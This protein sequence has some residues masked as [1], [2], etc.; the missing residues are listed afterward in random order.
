MSVMLSCSCGTEIAVASREAARGLKCP[1]CGK[2]AGDALPEAEIKPAPPADNDM[3]SGHTF[4][5]ADAD[6][7]AP[8]GIHPVLSTPPPLPDVDFQALCEEEAPASETTAP[9]A[10]ANSRRQLV[11]LGAPAAAVVLAALAVLV[12]WSMSSSGRN[13]QQARNSTEPVLSPTSNDVKQKPAE[14]KPAGPALKSSDSKPAV[15]KEDLKAPKLSLE[16]VVALLERDLGPRY[17]EKLPPRASEGTMQLPTNTAAFPTHGKAVE[18]MLDNAVD[19]F[20]LYDVGR[21]NGALG[22]KALADFRGLNDSAG[23]ALAKGLHKASFMEASCPVIAIRSKLSELVMKTENLAMVQAVHDTL[24]QLQEASKRFPAARH[25]NNVE[26][27]IE[28]CKIRMAQLM[29]PRESAKP[30]VSG[31]TS[32]DVAIRRQTAMMLGLHPEEAR[33]VIPE[34]VACLKDPDGIVRGYAARALVEAGPEAVPALL[35]VLKDKESRCLACLVLGESRPIGDTTVKALADAMRDNDEPFSLAGQQGLIMIG[36]PAESIL[37]E[38][39]KHDDIKVRSNAAL[40]LAWIGPGAM[41]A[42]DPLARQEGLDR[43]QRILTTHALLRIDPDRLESRAALAEAVLFVG[44]ALSHPKKEVRAWAAGWLGEAGPRAKDAVPSLAKALADDE[45]QVRARAAD[46]LGKIGP[47]ARSA[48]PNLVKKLDDPELGVRTKSAVAMGKIGPD[49]KSAVPALIA[50]FDQKQPDLTAALSEALGKIGKS[51]LP[52]LIVA[53]GSSSEPVQN[54]AL[55]AV[56]KIGDASVPT[57]CTALENSEPKVR[58]TAALALKQI[59][60]GAKSAAPGLVAATQDK[61]ALVRQNAIAGLRS[62]DLTGEKSLTAYIQ[63]LADDDAEVRVGAQLGLVMAEKSALPSLAIALKNDKPIARRGA[64]QVIKRIAFEGHAK[65]E[66]N[67]LTPELILAACDK[68]EEVR[69]EIS[70]ALE[71]IDP[72]FKQ[73]LTGI[74]EALRA[75]PRNEGSKVASLKEFR[76]AQTADLVQAASVEPA[77][78]LKRVLSELKIRRGPEVLVA[79]ARAA[80]H[81]DKDVRDHARQVLQEHLAIKRDTGIEAKAAA[82]LSLI[83]QLAESEAR[84]AIVQERYRDLIR[85]MPGT[86]AADEARKLVLE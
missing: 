57:L 82:K 80:L 48:V 79:L 36:K 69:N 16:T 70:W 20:I 38:M 31:L 66:V 43:N 11:M 24:V 33:K 8:T 9:T 51:A 59:G 55:D 68:D 13:T 5:L 1:F 62:L 12:A 34:L 10:L 74:R 17:H 28:Q 41:D 30:S 15:G 7:A 29:G 81:E 78:R 49:A 19:R 60:P 67:A 77:A 50:A 35:E 3:P 40:V 58:A 63:A 18:A 2:L 64:A 21:L 56:V 14:K 37:I 46:S 84:K 39:L 22:Q 85:E 27:M 52:E 71:E 42:Y 32:A 53:F 44:D 23:V 4:T 45:V 26:T 6:A 75:P 25:K 54:G 47:D 76:Y 73:A 61:N 65:Q 83:Q 72:L 86:Q